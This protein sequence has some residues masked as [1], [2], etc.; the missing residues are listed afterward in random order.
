MTFSNVNIFYKDRDTTILL[1]IF[2][3]MYPNV[4]ILYFIN[5]MFSFLHFPLVFIVLFPFQ[6]I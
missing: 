5:Y 6:G 4:I 1:L 2:F 3:A